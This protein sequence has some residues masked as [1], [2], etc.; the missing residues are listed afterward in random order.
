[1]HVKPGMYKNKFRWQMLY[2]FHDI[3]YLQCPS[4]KISILMLLHFSLTTYLFE[5]FCISQCSLIT[6]E[7]KNS[8]AFFFFNVTNRLNTSNTPLFCY[9]CGFWLPFAVFCQS[10]LMLLNKDFSFIYFKSHNNYFANK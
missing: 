3:R 8:R 1:M 4:C 9:I 2:Y 5:Y 10:F 6:L 7:D